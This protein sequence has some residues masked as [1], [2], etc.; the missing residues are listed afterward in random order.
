MTTVDTGPRL[1]APNTRDAAVTRLH[2]ELEVARLRF[3][4]ALAILGTISD[5]VDD[6]P[7]Q[8]LVVADV[9][10]Q[11]RALNSATRIRYH[12]DGRSHSPLMWFAWRYVEDIS[13]Q[14]FAHY[15]DEDI[16]EPRIAEVVLHSH[17]QRHVAR[18]REVNG[19]GGG[20]H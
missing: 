9:V 2:D 12:E 7:D 11:W 5:H 14:P 6:Y 17:W 20:G 13:S 1:V 4:V 10:R 16:P 3:D 8:A 15:A 19:S 18:L